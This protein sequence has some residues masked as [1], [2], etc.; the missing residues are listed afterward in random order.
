MVGKRE[1][2]LNIKKNT[3]GK[4][5]E[6]VSDDDG[7]YIPVGG[8]GSG[9]VY[10]AN[11][12]FDNKSEICSKRAIKFFVFRE[13]LMEQWG[14][15]S[16]ENFN[17]EI[18]NIAQFNHQNI[19]KVIDGDYYEVS[20][21]DEIVPIPYMITEFIDG[22][23]L[24]SAL[25]NKNTC[26]SI[27]KTEE[28]VFSLFSQI[29]RGLVYLHD[30]HFYHCDIA[31]KNIFL[32]GSGDNLIA[33]VG[34]L[35]A[36]KIVHNHSFES[37]KII[38]TREYMPVEVVQKKGKEV[39]YEEFCKLQPNWDIYSTVETLKETIEK[40]K[41][42]IEH[43]S[44]LYNLDRLYEKLNEKRYENL[45]EIESD[46]NNL[47]PSNN[48]ILEIDEL[49]EANRNIE[50]VLIPINTAFL[51]HR[52]RTLS[53]HCAMLRLMDVPQLLEGAIS[54]P[55][56]NH[57]RYEHSLGTYELMRK[58]MLSLL[59][60]KD[61][62]KFLS[63][64]YVIIGLLASLFSSITTFPYS[65]A[66]TELQNQKETLYEDL[67]PENLFD[68]LI[69][70]KDNSDMS[71]K[72]YIGELFKEYDIKVDELKYVIFGKK[73]RTKNSGLDILYFLLNSSVGVRVIDYMMR[74]SHHI[75]LTYKINTNDLFNNMSIAG[76]EFCLYQPGV[77]MAEQ[78]IS[79][80]YWLFKRVY[81][82]DPNRA[83]A[84]LLKY[85]FYLAH[86][87]SLSRQ[88]SKTIFN[89]TRKDIQ[90]C[91]IEYSEDKNKN[92]LKDIFS[93]INQKG[94]KRYKSILSA[95][96]N[97]EF[98]FANRI[99][100]SFFEM[101]YSRQYDIR[102]KIEED[103]IVKYDI[104][105]NLCN[106]LPLLLIDMPYEKRG[107]KQGEDI[108]VQRYDGSFLNLP[109]ASGIISG[110]KNVFESELLLLRIYIH[111]D[112]ID[113]AEEKKIDTKELVQFLWEK[114]TEY[115]NY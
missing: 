26:Q 9:I 23:D 11:Q 17:V 43:S 53:K 38:G 42:N 5:Y 103:L 55:G 10:A 70:T 45:N 30:N 75:G 96:K 95:N 113:W 58:A 86:T 91:I 97:S 24:E 25:K 52:M 35:G 72:D 115:T 61:Y 33:I 15:V 73:G 108:R 2:Y 88:L 85:L 68:I 84:A 59:R 105:K 46:I 98:A 94:Q 8:G 110:L 77:M 57:T 65:Y 3:L 114:M 48:Q 112:L 41:C 83:N 74:D 92:C 109:V 79:N 19:L 71:L 101:P 100:M 18:Q 36:G 39:S 87:E 27:F 7:N 76:E 99:C 106:N 60:N 31:P 51:S 44:E 21:D 64:R 28:N 69:N 78:I 16:K 89:T 66:I 50:Q 6:F 34:D 56:A 14:Y 13:D 1:E 37:T 81:W 63:G 107:N 62:S 80:R 29:L 102:L 104:P 22:S 4:K 20:I 40:I 12:I 47:R 82:N 90:E 111:P 32:K 49:S 54:F 93:F 67:L